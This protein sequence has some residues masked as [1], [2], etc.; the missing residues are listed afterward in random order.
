[1]PAIF[2]EAYLDRLK[3]R[4]PATESHLVQ[5][6]TR[7]LRLKLGAKLR[8]AELV[9]EGCQETFLRVFTHFRSGKTIESPSRLPAFVHGVCN[10]VALELLRARRRY[11]Q[12]AENRNDPPDFQNPEIQASTQ[13]I[14]AIVTR[15]LSEM[16]SMD[17][18]ILRLTLL[19]E[20]DREEVCRKMG[21]NRGYLRVL[22]H[23]AK[24]RFKEVLAGEVGTE[25]GA[26]SPR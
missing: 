26:K 22:L 19:E 17:R 12:M 11:D 5:F 10:N 13:E 14:R 18:E 8:V 23:R 20:E 7:P 21:V 6:F 25:T 16:P 15:V 9:E 3:T 24:Q 1:L 4:D 2:D